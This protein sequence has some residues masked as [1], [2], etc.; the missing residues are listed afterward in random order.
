[1]IMKIPSDDL[2][3]FAVH[4]A[5]DFTEEDILKI[6]NGPLKAAEPK[7]LEELKKPVLMDIYALF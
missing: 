7:L 4:D 2:G 1:M 3:V 6:I 5:E